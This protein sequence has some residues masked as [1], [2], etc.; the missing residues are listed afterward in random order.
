VNKIKDTE[1]FVEPIS[2]GK[3]YQEAKQCSGF[4]DH[5]HGYNLRKV[6]FNMTVTKKVKIYQ[7]YDTLHFCQSI[8]KACTRWREGN[9]E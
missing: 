1:I 7:S 8:A 9:K 5:M 3:N 6:R 4:C 2:C